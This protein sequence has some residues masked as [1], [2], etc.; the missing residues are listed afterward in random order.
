[1][2]QKHITRQTR[3]FI[4]HRW[5]GTPKADWYPWLKTQLQKKNIDV[6]VPEMPTPN[7]PEITTWIKT[8]QDAVGIAD[9]NTFFVGHSVGC[10]TIL[11]YIETLPHETKIGGA[12]IVAP[13]FIL[14]PA[15]LPSDREKKIAKSWTKSTINFETV[16]KHTP[17]YIAI[18]SDNDPYV[19]L[20]NNKKI[21]E[22][23]CA[24]IIVEHE[25]GHFDEDTNT[26]EL[27]CALSALL[28]MMHVKK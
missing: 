27:P 2:N 8:L 20:E 24:R 10:Q 14:S 7:A 4:L 28:Q 5:Y 19:P 12:V 25:Q 22:Q 21:L 1:M 9:E 6:F 16:R 26:R 17:N 3:V 18:F 13:W 11:R 23:C 15:A